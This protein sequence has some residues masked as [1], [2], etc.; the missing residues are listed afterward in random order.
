MKARSF[1]VKSIDAL[2]DELQTT[3]EDH[4][5]PTVALAFGDPNVDISECLV[6]FQ[7]HHIELIGCTSAGEI[8]NDKIEDG[9]MGVLLLD[10]PRDTFEAIHFP[11]TGV[12]YHSV[13]AQLANFAADRF[14]N[15]AIIIYIGGMGVDGESAIHGIK[16]VIGEDAALYGGMGGDNFQ[17]ESIYSFD[18]H[19]FYDN[20]IAALVLDADRVEVKGVS[21][22]GWN[23]LGKA[24]E[25]TRSKG[26]VVFEVDGE[27]AL[28]LFNRYFKGLEYRMVEGSTQLFTHPGVYALSVKRGS[29]ESFMRS[30]LLFD[31][32]NRALVLAGGIK[33]GDTFR[34]CPTPSFEVI[35]DTLAVFDSMDEDFKKPAAII[36]NSCAARYLAFGPL[37][38][39]EIK[40]IWSIL[41][42]A[43]MIGYLAYGEIGKR[44]ED[45][46][47]AFHNVTCSLLTL[48]DGR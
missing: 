12:D 45:P 43:P 36:M 33:E 34:F 29:S 25:I 10:L 27:P 41:N 32:E 6:C 44:D 28:D 4:F 48:D 46:G 15:P 14:D 2:R 17:F 23:E 19:G 5:S 47:C 31:F 1:L 26:N 11:G 22:S 18:L 3:V 13:G 37:L 20:G 7:D 39:D 24:H 40:G 16:S 9:C 38:E 8:C 35:D 30:T 21:Y 42:K